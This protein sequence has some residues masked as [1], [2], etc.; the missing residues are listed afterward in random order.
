[1]GLEG[2]KILRTLANARRAETARSLLAYKRTRP[3]EYAPGPL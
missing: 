2:L 3:G 1:M